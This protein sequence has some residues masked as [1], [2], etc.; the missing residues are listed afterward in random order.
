MNFGQA[1]ELLKDRKRVAR[2]GWNGK[3]MYLGLCEGGG[4]RDSHR[5]QDFIY[6]KT[7]ND[8]IVPWLASQTDMLAEDWE[9]VQ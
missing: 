4:W 5:T 9:R 1:I 6:M 7:A 8:T 3:G 2:A